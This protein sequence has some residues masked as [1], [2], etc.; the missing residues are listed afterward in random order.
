[1]CFIAPKIFSTTRVL[2]LSEA[3]N[4]RQPYNKC[5]ADTHITN[6][7]IQPRF[8]EG[9]GIIRGLPNVFFPFSNTFSGFSFLLYPQYIHPYNATL[10]ELSLCGTSSRPRR[11]EN[12]LLMSLKWIFIRNAYCFCKIHCVQSV[13]NI[14]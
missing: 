13:V 6:T 5:K 10:Q 3:V 7:V 14:S 11:E 1:V 2:C 4:R 12:A 8:G 9:D